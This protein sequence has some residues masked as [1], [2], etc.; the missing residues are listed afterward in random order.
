M[1]MTGA[2]FLV[3]M[4]EH[5]GIDFVS[6]I[7]GG[8]ILPLYNA[9]DKSKIRHILA[10]HEQGAGFIAQGIARSRGDVSVCFATSGPGVTNLLTSIADAKMDSVPLVAITAQVSGNLIGSDAFQEIDTYGLTIPITKHNFLVRSVDDL[11]EII[12]EAFFIAETGRP[13][14]VV[15]DIP[16]DVLNATLEVE[17]LPNFKSKIKTESIEDDVIRIISEKINQSSRPLIIAG[18]G[19]SNIKTANSL[20]SLA[21]KNNIPVAF[22]LRG[23]GLLPYNHK[24]NLG[25]IGMHGSVET[26]K[27]LEEADLIIAFGMRFDDRA[28]GK[29]SEFCKNAFIIHVD[30][31]KSEFNKNRNVDLTINADIECLLETLISNVDINERLKWSKKIVET[32]T[33]ERYPQFLIK[34]ISGFV[35]ETSFIVTDVGQHQMWVAQSYPFSSPFKLLT[36]GGLGTMGFGLPVA[37]GA[38]LVNIDHKVIC[39]SGDGSIMMNI[40]ELSTLAENNLDITIIIFNNSGLGMVRQQQELFYNKNFVASKFY[41][42]PDFAK[43]AEGFGIKG[44]DLS[45]SV[46]IITDLQ[47]ALKK[48]GPLLINIPIEEECNVMPIVMPGCANTSYI[49]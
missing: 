2:E 19:I 27:K 44:V 28:T 43:I 5:R 30:I 35:P 21:E 17:N 26:N 45:A 32:K 25:M 1:K 4:L 38:A 48:R 33:D 7:P 42:Q 18:G 34:L 15:V 31:D 13:G 22:T 37:I 3:R 36:S 46:D 16:K 41:S 8:A 23:L 29:V 20:R 49:I 14:P 47:S 39:I 40:Q 11:P 24:L 6:G 12:V 9:L 10:R